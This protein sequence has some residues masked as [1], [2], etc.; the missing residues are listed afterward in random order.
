MPV[1]HGAVVF[2]PSLRRDLVVA[3]VAGGQFLEGGRGGPGPGHTA[4][5]QFSRGRATLASWS[6]RW[7]M[8]ALRPSMKCGTLLIDRA[9]LM[10]CSMFFLASVNKRSMSVSPSNGT[11][12][13]VS[14]V[15]VGFDAG[16]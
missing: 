12:V 14:G 2:G 13:V 8:N 15:G 3:T 4:A 16:G 5:P 10:N 11:V 9:R 6:S 7:S 1:G